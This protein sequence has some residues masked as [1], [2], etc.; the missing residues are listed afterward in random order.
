MSMDDILME[1]LIIGLIIGAVGIFIGTRIW[2][3]FK[4]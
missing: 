2:M 3:V 4:T 1:I